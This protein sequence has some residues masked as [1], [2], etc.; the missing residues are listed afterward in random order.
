MTQHRKVIV[1]GGAGFIGSHTV[2][3]LYAAGYQ[4]IIV[5]NFS[6][7]L[8]AVIDRLETILGHPV[9]CHHVDC[10]D[11]SALRKVFEEEGEIAGAIHFAAYKAVGESVEEPLKYYH[12]NITSLV[13]LLEIMSEF[14]VKS[15]VFSSSCT[16]YGQP[17]NLPVT[18]QTP[19]APPQSPYGHTKQICEAI[20]EDMSK[21]GVGNKAISL[22]YFN[23]IGAHPTSLI[24]ELPLSVPM[25]LIPFLT[26]TAAGIREKLTVFGDDYDTSDGSCVRDYI[27][28]VDLAKAH[29]KALDWLFT[30]ASP[31]EHE[32]IN[33]GTGNGSSVLEVIHAFEAISKLDLNYEIGPRRAG[34]VEQI[35][36]NCDKATK[37]LGWQTE[38]SLDEAIRDA[39]NWQCSLPS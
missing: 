8:E 10:T 25:N 9:K 14:D 27:H 5:D 23:P 17:E 38:L 39:W 15:L 20:L 1:T 19:M 12:N 22:R 29:V 21:T 24:G 7:S 32:I 16:V 30:S 18:E 6:N 37:V 35:W 2:V 36:A 26:Q 33:L 31:N 11:K 28:V 3:E 4:P 34:D 13:T